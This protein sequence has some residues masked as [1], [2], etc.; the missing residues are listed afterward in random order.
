MAGYN[1]PLHALKQK[2]T[3][4]TI[5]SDNKSRMTS[6]KTILKIRKCNEGQF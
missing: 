6:K 5:A 2:H 4:N 1:R 3:L